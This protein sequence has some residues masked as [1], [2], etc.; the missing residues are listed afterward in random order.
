MSSRTDQTNKKSRKSRKSKNKKTPHSDIV[1]NDEEPDADAQEQTNKGR[2]ADPP[3][4]HGSQRETSLITPWDQPG[5]FTRDT[6]F[7]QDG[8]DDDGTGLRRRL[9]E[10]KEQRDVE[11]Q[12]SD[13][14]FT[15]QLKLN[16]ELDIHL[17]ANIYGDVTL[18]VL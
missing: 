10:R 16:L 1:P 13:R 6:G 7:F 15:V 18:S 11:R 17:K 2:H 14:A 8:S 12:K 4:H 3:S 9:A 5:G